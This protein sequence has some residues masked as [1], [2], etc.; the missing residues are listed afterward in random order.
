M[1]VVDYRPRTPKQLISMEFKLMK[2]SHEHF[3]LKNGILTLHIF[4]LHFISYVQSFAN[5]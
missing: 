2:K 3:F 4:L 5:I 1:H